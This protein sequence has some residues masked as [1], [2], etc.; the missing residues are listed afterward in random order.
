[1]SKHTTTLMDILRSELIKKGENE[2][3]NNGRLTFFDNDYAFIEK[4][5]R[6]DDDVYNIVTSRFFGGR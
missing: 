2:F 6:F 4:V 1:M 3:I 5:A